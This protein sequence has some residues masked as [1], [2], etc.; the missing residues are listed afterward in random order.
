[1]TA[2]LPRYESTNPRYPNSTLSSLGGRE[3][4]ILFA[5]A[6]CVLP[7]G[8]WRPNPASQPGSPT[9]GRLY[10]HQNPRFHNPRPVQENGTL[11]EKID[12]DPGRAD[13]GIL[14]NDEAGRGKHNQQ[15]NRIDLRSRDSTNMREQRG[16]QVSPVLASGHILL[17]ISCPQPDSA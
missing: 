4:N 6:T 2:F 13:L 17:L 9:S 10:G 15:A 16:G 7:R 14:D 5:H 3:N 11:L 12:P 1:M 8:S